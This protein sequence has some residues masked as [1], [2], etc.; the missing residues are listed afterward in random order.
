V[1]FL[2]AGNIHRA[3]ASKSINDVHGALSVLPLSSVLLVAGF[4][5]GCGSPPFGPFISEFTIFSATMA[6]ERYWVGGFFLLLL[7]IVFIGMG[8]TILSV[9]FGKSSITASDTPYRDGLLTGG[10]VVLFMFFV[11]LFGVYLPAPIRDLLN[12]GAA[13]L[14]GDTADTAGMPAFAPPL[15]AK[16]APPAISANRPV[17]GQFEIHGSQ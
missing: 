1:L 11:V 4:L 10:P 13:F 5:A 16:A 14:E 6:S 2:S 17:V 3:Y 12:D 8:S 9:V 7:L 15:V